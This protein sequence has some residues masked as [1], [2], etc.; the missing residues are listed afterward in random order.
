MFLMD[1]IRDMDLS[2][3]LKYLFVTTDCEEYVLQYDKELNSWVSDIIILSDNEV[4]SWLEEN[5]VY[6]SLIQ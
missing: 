4:K 2:K 6:V 3:N 1:Q 5:C